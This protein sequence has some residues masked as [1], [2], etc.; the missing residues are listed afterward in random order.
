MWLTAQELGGRWMAHSM[1][2]TPPPPHHTVFWTKDLV[3]GRQRLG[4][5]RKKSPEV[6]RGH[7][8]RLTLL[9]DWAA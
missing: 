6:T 5:L 9:S 8:A 2:R 1:I 7:S 3:G 4:S